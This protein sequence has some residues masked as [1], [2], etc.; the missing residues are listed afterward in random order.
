MYM[1][2]HVHVHAAV[3]VRAD[4]H[5][6]VMTYTVM[7]YT[8]MTCTHVACIVMASIVTAHIVMVYAAMTTLVASQ[9]GVLHEFSETSVLARRY[10]LERS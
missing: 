2:S 9:I 10:S 7:A 1:R 8:V 5:H 3:H 6:I 4:F